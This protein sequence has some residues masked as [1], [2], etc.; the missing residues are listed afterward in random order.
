MRRWGVALCLGGF[1]WGGIG[2]AQGE[3]AQAPS[4][5]TDVVAVAAGDSVELSWNAATDPDGSVSQYK[6]YYGIAS[7]QT[8][9]DMYDIEIEVDA[10][11]GTSYVIEGLDPGT[12]YFALTAIDDEGL[13]SETY[14]QEVSVTIDAS[15][16]VL[17]SGEGTPKVISAE[18]TDVSIVSVVMS[19]PVKISVPSDAFILQN[20]DT[21][22]EVFIT[23]ASIDGAT[24]HISVLDTDMIEDNT[25]ELIATSLVQDY[26]GNPVSSGITDSVM[27]VAQHFEPEVT[28]T[29]VNDG[30]E[31][32][33]GEGDITIPEDDPFAG[34]E[35]EVTPDDSSEVGG[36]V[37]EAEVDFPSAPTNDT[38]PPQDAT[39]LRMSENLMASQGI[40]VLSWTPAFDVD[41]DIADQVLYVRQGLGAWDD[42]Y[43]LG[44]SIDEI[45]LEIVEN[46][47]YEVKVV[48]VDTAGNESAGVVTSFST[49]LSK[50]G[51][52]A[53]IFLAIGLVAAAGLFFFLIREAV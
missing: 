34:F 7:V 53:N 46:Q 4:E 15:K 50:T 8:I 29:P 36:F 48:T 11:D 28:D 9:D 39:N 17:T 25:Y 51:P 45:E 27:F 33:E 47:N 13:E 21:G 30:W 1:L 40:V 31:E 44:A 3:F 2:F 10:F 18:H 52:D 38:T 19:E 42:G 26:D 6:I 20:T 22:K 49:H 24:V 14:S 41:D 23:G 12:Y 43:S 35:E 32:W 16:E 5:V 37:E